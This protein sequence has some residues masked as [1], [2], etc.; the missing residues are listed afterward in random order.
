MI[1]RRLAGI[2]ACSLACVMACHRV[3][4]PAAQPLDWNADDSAHV[5]SLETYGRRLA[6]R[7]V[8]VIAPPEQ[9]SAEWQAALLDS[10]DRGVYELRRLIGAPLPWM[11][12]G[13]RPVLYYLI[14]ERLISHASGKDVVFISMVRVQDGRAPYL[15]EAVHELLAPPPPF[16]YD[17]Y[18]DTL[19]AE[20]QFQTQPYW[21]MEG[22]PDVL[23]Q[24]AAS[25]AGTREGDVFGIGGLEKADSTCAA[26]L[27]ENEFRVDLLRTVGGRGAIDALFTTDRI[28]VAPTFYACSQSMSKF[29]VEVIGMDRTVALF[30]AIK[31]GDWAAMIERAAGMPL[32][33]IRS[34]WQARLGLDSP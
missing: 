22:L 32:A 34:R 3:P 20:T 2:L 1:S 28:K 29:L 10:L 30:P 9:I 26:R 15:H 12:I 25:A 31:G 7:Q 19:Q 16:F 17:E 27:T 14:P 18:P 5:A 8:V 6:G 4:Q 23:A 13:M 11:R 24:L 33:A 21:L